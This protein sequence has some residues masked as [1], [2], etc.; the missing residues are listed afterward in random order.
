[1]RLVRALLASLVLF[2]AIPVASAQQPLPGLDDL[3]KR[4][5]FKEAWDKVFRRER[6]ID[7]WVHVFGGGGEGTVQPTR[8]IARDGVSYLVGVVC[9]P[10]ACEDNRLFVLF[11][12]DGSQAWARW[13]GKD[14]ALTYGQP[15]PAMR[16]LLTE[17]A[18]R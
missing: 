8:A 15:T 10:Q 3:L 14:L 9:R 11:R 16:A 5:A 12:E 18:G 13:V 7:R 4:P 17:V 6:N 2:A 1:M